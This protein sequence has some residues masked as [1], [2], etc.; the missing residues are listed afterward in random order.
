MVEYSGLSLFN[1]SDSDTVSEGGDARD[2][3]L[4]DDL[5]ILDESN[6]KQEMFSEENLWYMLSHRAAQKFINEEAFC[7]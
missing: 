4:R 7:K 6:T 2:D 3:V 5:D 1:F